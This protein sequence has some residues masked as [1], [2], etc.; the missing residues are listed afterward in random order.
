MRAELVLGTRNKIESE[1]VD[2]S[3]DTSDDNFA[4]PEESDTKDYSVHESTIDPDTGISSDT[5]KHNDLPENTDNKEES[6]L[7]NA[8][9]PGSLDKMDYL[10]KKY[11]SKLM[12]E[13]SMNAESVS[14]ESVVVHPGDDQPNMEV[15]V[16]KV[17]TH[18]NR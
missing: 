17:N 10:H 6:D 2:E 1:M 16:R 5:L 13:V 8:F 11:R 9:D 4:F 14:I 12:S 15:T 18:Q 7:E 3:S